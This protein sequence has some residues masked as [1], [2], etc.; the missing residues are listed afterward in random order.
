VLRPEGGQL[1]QIRNTIGLLLALWLICSA[2]PAT[3]QQEHVITGRTMGT[4]YQVKVVS[5]KTQKIALLKERV[6]QR[7]EQINQSMSTYRPASEISRFNAVQQKGEPFAVSNDFLR[8]MQAGRRIHGLSQ[9][10]WDA[11]VQPLVTLWGFGKADPIDRL[12]SEQAIGR[13]KKVVDFDAIE[14]MP[15]GHLTKRRAGV[16]VDLASIAKGYGVDQVAALLSGMGFTQYLVEI[17]G[18]VYAAGRRAD[19]QPW[20]IGINQPRK[21]GRADAVYRVVALQDQAMA[22]S[23]DY[24]NFVVIDGRS[25]SHIIDPRTGWPVTNGVVSASVIAADCTLADGLATGVMV[26]GPATGL[27]LLNGLDGVEGLIIVR[28]PDGTLVNHWSDGLEMK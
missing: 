17:G 16:T 3:A 5:A 21:G 22:T 7:L 1:I 14:I 2:A 26:M 28:K 6:D 9:G 13:T 24:R 23:G 11:T 25:Y 19:G 12:P 27:A 15:D 20:R 4:R 10:A 18:E 8:V